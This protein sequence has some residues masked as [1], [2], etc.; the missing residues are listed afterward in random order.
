[1]THKS[2]LITLSLLSLFASSFTTAGDNKGQAKITVNDAYIRGLPP[3][4]STT[5]AF[6]KITNHSDKAITLKKLSSSK[7][8]SVELHESLMNDGRM[9]MRAVEKFSIKAHQS[10]SLTAGGKHLMFMGLTQTLKEGDTVDLQLCFNEVC[11]HLDLPVVS[12]LNEKNDHSH[13]HH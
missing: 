6:M 9:Q 7:A 10:A 11:Q 2:L 4:Q 13:H 8:K 12:V 1:M 5:A 3:G